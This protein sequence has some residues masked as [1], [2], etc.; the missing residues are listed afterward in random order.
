MTRVQDWWV[1]FSVP[2]RTQSYIPDLPSLL[3][4]AG[5]LVGKSGTEAQGKRDK[6]YQISLVL[7]DSCPQFKS[8]VEKI[9]GVKS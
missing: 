4:D 5:A 1:S 9:A 8:R 3:P 7:L 2:G 6:R